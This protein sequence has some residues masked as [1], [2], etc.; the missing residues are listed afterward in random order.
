M[1]YEYDGDGG[2]SIHGRLELVV[3]FRASGKKLYY[4]ET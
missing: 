4:S 1:K 3:G 2:E